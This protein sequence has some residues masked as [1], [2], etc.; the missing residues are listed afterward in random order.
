MLIVSYFLHP[1]KC[2]TECYEGMWGVVTQKLVSIM[3]QCKR[4]LGDPTS[5]LE[6][7][8]KRKT[9]WGWCK[10]THNL[11]VVQPTALSLYWLSYSSYIQMNITNTRLKNVDTAVLIMSAVTHTGSWPH[12]ISKTVLNTG[13][14][15]HTKV[16][17]VLISGFH[18]ASLLSVTF[19]NQLMHS[20]IR[21]V[22]VKILL[23][24]SL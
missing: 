3:P 7:F 23:Y 14:C 13:T 2:V 1:D 17:S 18:C 6:S 24:I 11:L 4:R 20:I 21:V 12:C 9:S 5:D 15:P 22:D 16:T 19:I 8:K 10:M